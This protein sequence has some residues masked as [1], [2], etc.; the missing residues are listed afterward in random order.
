VTEH[1]ATTEALKLTSRY[2]QT[3]VMHL[4]RKLLA[5]QNRMRPIATIEGR[6]RSGSHSAAT[7]NSNIL[8][9]YA[10][11]SGKQIPTCQR[12]AAPSFFRW[13]RF[14]LRGLFD[15]QAEIN[16]ICRNV[17]NCSP[18]DMTK[19]PRR[20]QSSDVKGRI[21]IPGADVHAFHLYL[22]SCGRKEPMVQSRRV[23][24]F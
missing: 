17:R 24:C 13:S 16:A 18:I 15:P 10:V 5:F 8:W 6:E 2:S 19:H 3:P 4:S 14:T 11:P 7:E 12:K 20:L 23:L 22:H 21:W 1:S 9:C